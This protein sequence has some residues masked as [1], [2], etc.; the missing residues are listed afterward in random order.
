MTLG[1]V[2]GRADEHLD[3]IVV[4]TVVELALKFPLELRMIE[5][6]G[7]KFEV[8]GMDRYRW[9][10]EVNDYFYPF[11]FRAGGKIQQGVLVEFQLSQ[12]AFEPRVCFFG[13]STILSGVGYV[14]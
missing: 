9:V 10:L 3:H 2:L 5:I 1:T 11:A 6:T 7:M 14:R 12:N 4:Q 8:I 13:H